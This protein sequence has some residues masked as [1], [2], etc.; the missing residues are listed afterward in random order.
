MPANLICTEAVY[1]NTEV[2]RDGMMSFISRALSLG[3]EKTFI[4]YGS[5]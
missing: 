4:V 1:V 5:K 3:M 2:F